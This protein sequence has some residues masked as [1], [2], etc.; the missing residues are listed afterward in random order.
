MKQ[1]IQITVPNDWSAVTLR[2]YIRLANDLQNYEGDDEATTAALFFHL[3]KFDVRMLKDLDVE[4]YSSIKD[5]LYSFLQNTNYPLQREIEID[6]VKYGFEPNLSQ[7][8]YG[9]YVDISK[10]DKLE[11]NDKWAEVMS[12]L[13]RPII[14]R[15]GKLYDII[16]YE[17]LIDSEL[18]MDVTMDI[19]FGCLF[20]FVNLSKDL[21]HSTLSSLMKTSPELVPHKLKSIL[22]RS[23]SLTLP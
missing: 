23:G 17:G 16:P 6:G 13:Y 9:A 11:I 10:Y 14:K 12:I 15:Y 4:T 21:W 7:M 8:A 2:E 19:H 18:F 5:K 20:F 22:E 1:Q 3:A